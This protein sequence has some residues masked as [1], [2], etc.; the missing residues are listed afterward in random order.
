MAQAAIEASRSA[1]ANFVLIGGIALWRLPVVTKFS[2]SGCAQ[3]QV[4]GRARLFEADPWRG[5][6]SER[7]LRS[8][9]RARTGRLHRL[10]PITRRERR[11][12]PATIPAAE[13]P[14]SRQRY[15]HAG[16]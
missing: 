9:R 15:I 14:R 4:P 5:S 10:R 2:E 7:R 1:F 6:I 8:I 16:C 12:G 3:A 11:S 13:S